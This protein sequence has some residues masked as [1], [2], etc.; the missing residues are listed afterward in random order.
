MSLK[1]TRYMTT[2]NVQVLDLFKC[3]I[4]SIV[5][6]HS[7]TLDWFWLVIV[8][9][10][11]IW[12][13]VDFFVDS[14]VGHDFQMEHQIRF[15]KSIQL[16]MSLFY[17]SLSSDPLGHL[18]NSWNGFESKHTHTHIIHSLLEFYKVK[19]ILQFFEYVDYD[20]CHIIQSR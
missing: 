13:C 6:T 5:R 11:P 10:L 14:C 19:R 15:V 20:C 17:H 7:S 9:H 1:A 18:R 8:S 12:L 4:V 16:T 2:Q 3:F